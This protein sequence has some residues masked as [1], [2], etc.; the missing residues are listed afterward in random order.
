MKT[1]A[2]LKKRQKELRKEINR[3][4]AAIFRLRHLAKYKKYH[5]EYMRK[6]RKQ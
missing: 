3:I 1:L 6:L 4:D 5:R 2:Q